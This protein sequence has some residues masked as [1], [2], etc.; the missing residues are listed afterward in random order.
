MTPFELDILLHY[1]GHADDHPVVARN[2][3]IWKETRDAF[4]E[5]GLLETDTT[6]ES[7]ATYRLT[8]RGKAYIDAMLALPLPV[9]IWVM[10]PTD[11]CCGDRERS[12]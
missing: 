1:Y 9:Q 4:R 7:T 5:K 12:T 10:P 3:P 8:E 6:M 2:P 11:R